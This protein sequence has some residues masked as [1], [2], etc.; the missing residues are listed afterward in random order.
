M[1]F[2]KASFLMIILAF[3]F[4]SCKNENTT[5]FNPE[6]RFEISKGKETATY[7]EMI[8]F[9]KDASEFSKNV[10]LKTMGT[11]D[12]GEPLHL[13]SYYNRKKSEN[14]INILINN[15]IHPGEPD[16]IDASMILLRDLV[17]KSVELPE[18]I[19]LHIIPAYNVGGMLKRNSTSRANQNGPKAYGF[20]G[21]AK[22]YDLNRDFI[23]MDTKNMEAFAEIYHLISPDVYVETHVSNGADYQY[24]LTHLFT[25]HNKLGYDLGEFTNKTF[26]PE[27]EKDLKNK[28]Y[29]IT[30]YVNVFGRTPNSGITQ[31]FDSPRYS[32]GYT[33][34]WNTIGLMIETHM[35]KP[36][37]ERVTQTKAMLE[38]VMTVSGKYKTEILNK[39]N[40]N[41]EDFRRNKYYRYNYVT[42]SENFDTL[43]FKG[44]GYE[45]VKSEVTDQQRLKYNND[46]PQTFPV[47]YYNRYI[48]EDSI[49]IPD[50]YVIPHAWSNILNKLK[51]N[52][53]EVTQV[54]RDI[55][56]TVESYRILDYKTYTSPYEGHYLHYNTKVEKSEKA[57]NVKQGDYIIS[58]N[59]RSRRYIIETLEPALRD[60]FFN[61]N[62]F[63]SILQQKEGFSAYV[64]EDYAKDFLVNHPEINEEFINKKQQDSVFNNSA[65]QQLNWIFKKS[66]LYEEAHLRYPVFR[67]FN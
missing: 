13:V 46:E 67:M 54:E 45:Y 4:L 43:N 14:S 47:K 17:N 37:L 62:F 3:T 21:N 32:T 19:N 39:R 38:S 9:Y 28:G 24:T 27:I 59:Q 41:F 50:F 33:S 29:P 8:A 42:D 11:T 25:Q 53:V 66:P 30:P 18:H 44:F 1:P 57:V 15:G 58:T 64:F 61:W 49:I 63:D 26:R 40:E 23:K 36:Y 16:G 5:K 52:G 51:I 22:N 31:F 34:L 65:Y 12:A 55:V 56:L 35:L 7:Q 48:A 2:E 10:E 20:R 60:S 6:L